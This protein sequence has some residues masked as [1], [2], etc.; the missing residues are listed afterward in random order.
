MPDRESEPH[1]RGVEDIRR[2]TGA[3]RGPVPRVRGWRQMRLGETRRQK[4]KTEGTWQRGYTETRRNRERLAT[5]SETSP[6]TAKKDW[7][8]IDRVVK[9]T[10]LR[11]LRAPANLRIA[12]RYAV[13]E[14]N[15]VGDRADARRALVEDPHRIS[16]HGGLDDAQH[17]RHYRQHVSLDVRCNASCRNRIPFESLDN[18]FL[19]R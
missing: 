2:R 7:G 5:D 8:A 10:T 17:P 11:L 14:E 13:V 1:T 4:K 6:Q 15:D 12:A 9:V 18:G 19:S 3:V 16:G